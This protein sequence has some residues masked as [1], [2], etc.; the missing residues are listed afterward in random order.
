MNKYEEAIKV[1]SECENPES[2]EFAQAV[3][4]AIVAL[5]QAA[6]R[7]ENKP[8]TYEE[9]VAIAE[10]EPVHIMLYNGNTAT[11]PAIIHEDGTV[12][13]GKVNTE[14]VVLWNTAGI[15]LPLTD[16]NKRFALYRYPT[17][18]TLNEGEN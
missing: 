15:T 18:T 6:K 8:L 9:A 17:K 5:E 11:L 13:G 4:V 12:E 16:I 10:K 3:E 14:L 2:E 7:E 1:F